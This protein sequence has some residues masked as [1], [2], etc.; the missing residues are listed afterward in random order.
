MPS[1]RCHWIAPPQPKSVVLQTP[2]MPV[3]SAAKSSVWEPARSPPSWNRKKAMVAKM[4]GWRTAVRM[5][6]S[7]A[8]NARTVK[9]QTR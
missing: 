8:R 4:I 3:P 9:S 7:L 5:K 2:I 1:Q 6:N